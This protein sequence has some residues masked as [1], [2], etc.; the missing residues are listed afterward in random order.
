MSK[1]DGTRTK[2]RQLRRGRLDHI[3]DAMNRFR[4]QSPQLALPRPHLPPPR[5][6]RLVLQEFPFTSEQSD[7]FR[8]ALYDVR[9][10]CHGTTANP[11]HPR[12]VSAKR[13]TTKCEG[14]RTKNPSSTYLSTFNRDDIPV[15]VDITRPQR[16]GQVDEERIVRN[17]LSHSPAFQN[18]T[19]RGLP[20]SSHAGTGQ[21]LHWRP[22]TEPG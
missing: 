9:L 12:L 15:I 3:A 18:R 19:R 17:V 20:P 22:K 13:P 5:R 7:G 14:T 8:E 4:C 16:H 11:Y 6:P 21:R 2:G 1:Q 10:E